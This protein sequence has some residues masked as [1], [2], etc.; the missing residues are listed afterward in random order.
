MDFKDKIKLHFR[1]ASVNGIVNVDEKIGNY[2]NKVERMMN[3]IYT[4]AGHNRNIVLIK[5]EAKSVKKKT[6]IFPKKKKRSSHIRVGPYTEVENIDD[7]I[8]IIKNLLEEENKLEFIE[9]R[10]KQEQLHKQMDERY[11]KNKMNINLNKDLLSEALTLS[12]NHY[13]MKIISDNVF[14]QRRD[15]PKK[16]I[17]SPRPAFATPEKPKTALGTNKTGISFFPSSR[18]IP[19]VH[20]RTYSAA[21]INVKTHKSPIDLQKMGETYKTI[22]KKCNTA[23]SGSKSLESSIFSAIPNLTKLRMHRLK[24]DLKSEILDPALLNH[25]RNETREYKKVKKFF[26]FSKRQQTPVLVSDDPNNIISKIHFVDGISEEAAYNSRGLINNKY[27]V[28]LAEDDIL[29][30]R[31]DYNS[32]KSRNKSLSPAEK[33]QINNHQLRERLYSTQMSIAKSNSKLS[34]YL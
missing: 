30:F 19:I 26:V 31:S 2:A 22:R 18:N 29:G 28:R 3:T 23:M 10:K 6:Y 25:M 34:L 16:T 14:N 1:T 15:Q 5:K 20:K 13:K 24:M 7:Q 21:D 32:Y 12:H 8:W 27:N 4:A 9:K 17:I 11:K 33:V